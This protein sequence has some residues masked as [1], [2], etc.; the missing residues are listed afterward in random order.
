MRTAMT[1]PMN[2]ID[3][4]AAPTAQVGKLIEELC[5]QGVEFKALGEVANIKN[6]KDWKMLSSGDVPVYGTGGIM[7]YVDKFS[8]DQPTV[9]IPRKGSIENV[10]YLE[11]PFWNIDTVYYTEIDITCLALPAHRFLQKIPALVAELI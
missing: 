9:L 6:G 5:P 4:P 8:Y 1:K 2:K 7:G 11:E 10:F 3:L